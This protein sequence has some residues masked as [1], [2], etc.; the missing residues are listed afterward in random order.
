MK[1]I[2]IMAV[3]FAA[4]TAFGLDSPD[5][6]IKV[7]DKFALAPKGAVEMKGVLGDELDTSLKGDILV[8]DIDDL[9]RPFKLRQEERLWQ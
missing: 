8:W 2:S 6:Q 1:K 4:A 7:K 9:V 5:A 3:L